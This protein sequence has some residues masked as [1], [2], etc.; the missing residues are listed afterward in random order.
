MPP[1]LPGRVRLRRAFT[2]AVVTFT[3]VL[4]AGAFLVNAFERQAAP[5]FGIGRSGFVERW[6]EAARTIDMP[7]LVIPGVDWTDEEAGVFGHAFSP[8]LSVLGRVEGPLQDVVEL[9]VVGTPAED[10]E[11]RVAAALELAVAVADPALSPDERRGVLDDLALLGPGR[12]AAPDVTVDLGGVRYR[13]ASDPQA[14]RIGIGAT[15]I[16]S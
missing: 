14:G 10:G 12:P 1:E 7:G 2:A 3:A 13:S 8:T 16:D 15:A 11:E 6:N 4:A 5:S 9:A